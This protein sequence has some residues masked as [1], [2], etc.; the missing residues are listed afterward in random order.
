MT[1]TTLR[2]GREPDETLLRELDADFGPCGAVA[3]L[4]LQEGA[5]VRV[6]G[7]HL[8]GDLTISGPITAP[9]RVALEMAFARDRSPDQTRSFLRV[10]S[11]YE[12]EYWYLSLG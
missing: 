7:H 9:L 1:M 3:R 12:G 5:C 4:A 2:D 10:E 8:G 6:R 11:P